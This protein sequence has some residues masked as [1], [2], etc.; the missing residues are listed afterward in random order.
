VLTGPGAADGQLAADLA[1]RT[2]LDVTV[3]EP[4]GR[5]GTHTVPTDD[6]PYRYTIAAGLALG[7]S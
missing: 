7:T 5:L 6:D 3:A 1:V 4:L 2:G